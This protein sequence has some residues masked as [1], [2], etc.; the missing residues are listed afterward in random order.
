MQMN[1]VFDKRQ[2]QN[3]RCKERLQ[4]IE[5]KKR[6]KSNI[7]FLTNAK[8]FAHEKVLWSHTTHMRLVS[9][10]CRC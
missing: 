7:L 6:N 8:F 9:I 10:V 1:I 3:V 2:V 5:R 4:Y